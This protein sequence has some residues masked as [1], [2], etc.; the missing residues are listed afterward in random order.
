MMGAAASSAA[1]ALHGPPKLRSGAGYAAWRADMEVHLARIGCESVHKYALT[2]AQWSKLVRTTEEWKNEALAKALASFGISAAEQDADGSAESSAAG[3]SA[4]ASDAAAHREQMN[5][6]VERSSRAYGALY[7][8]LDADLRA[9]VTQSGDVPANF[10][11]GLWKWLERKFQSTEE[12]SVDLL[13]DQW[14]ELHQGDGESFDAYRARVNHLDALLKHA[15][16]EQSKRLYI[17][18]LLRKLRA[19]YR[20][21]VQAI[22]LSGLLKDPAKVAWDTVSAEINAHEL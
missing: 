15:G 10:A 9:Q 18:R 3:S 4:P 12:D 13:L 1:L 5:K 8:A 7:T 22:K 21:V 16:E 19:E 6:L 20:P 2:A 17:Y 14:N 11:Y